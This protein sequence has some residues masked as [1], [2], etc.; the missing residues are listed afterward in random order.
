MF[1]LR[2]FGLVRPGTDNIVLDALSPYERTYRLKREVASSIL[3][4]S[5]R[6]AVAQ[7]LEHLYYRA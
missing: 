6:G 4:G 3:V 5:T 7:W 1:L 2:L